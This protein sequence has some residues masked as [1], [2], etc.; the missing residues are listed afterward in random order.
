MS[1]N[2]LIIL[3]VH[4]EIEILQEVFVCYRVVHNTLLLVFAR[5]I[6]HELVNATATP[7]WPGFCTRVTINVFTKAVSALY[8]RQY[9]QQYLEQLRKQVCAI[10]TTLLGK[11]PTFEVKTSLGAPSKNFVSIELD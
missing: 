11:C 5:D 7:D 9:S 2:D 6:L 3:N 10:I 1:L 4:K 8:V